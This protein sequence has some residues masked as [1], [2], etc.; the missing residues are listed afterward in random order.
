MSTSLFGRVV[1]VQLGTANASG[2][3]FTGLRVGFSVQMTNSS[4]P[5]EGRI[6]VY[7]VAPQTIATMQADDA[8]I[9][10][11][12]GYK[13]Q[14]G[15][16][17]QIFQGSPIK[18]GVKLERRGVDKVLVV[19]AQDGGREFTQSHISESFSTATTTAQLFA[20]ISRSFGLPLGNISAVVGDIEFPHGLG[21]TGQ[22]AKM[23]DR[24]AE[25][26]NARWQIRDGTIQVWARGSSTG[27]SAV[28]F[29]AESG[30]LI[31]TPTVTDD[32]VEITGLMAPTL[33]P[34][35][36]FRVVSKDVNGDYV[37]TNVEFRGDSGFATEFYVVAVGTPI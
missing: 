24:V 31:G 6:E 27:E 32:G 10:L 3:S 2:K 9:R 33:R 5:N 21:L 20:T 19:E 18:G 14:G 28:V 36:P 37:A 22:A 34:G 8:I 11:L 29:S 35:K 4:D 23:M 26:S 25:L 15:T 1:E 30:N 13:S 12:V 7:N 16:V 17:R